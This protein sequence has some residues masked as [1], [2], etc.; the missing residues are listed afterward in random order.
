M[1]YY[2]KTCFLGLINMLGGGLLAARFLIFCFGRHQLT[3]LEIMWNSG[4]S[5]QAG[6]MG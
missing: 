2:L 1:I 3:N 6:D 5:N 4:C